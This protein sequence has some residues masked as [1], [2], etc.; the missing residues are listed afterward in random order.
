MNEGLESGLE[1]LLMDFDTG[2]GEESEQDV[3]HQELDVLVLL[4][5]ASRDVLHNGIDQSTVKNKGVRTLGRCLVQIYVI[6][7]VWTISVE[8]VVGY[9]FLIKT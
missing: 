4:V 8:K 2:V 3:D 5:H 7:V 9:E 1:T 6:C